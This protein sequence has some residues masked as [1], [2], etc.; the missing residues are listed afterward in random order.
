MNSGVAPIWRPS[1]ASNASPLMVIMVIHRRYLFA[2][3]F[4]RFV[5]EISASIAT[6]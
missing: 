2:W 1:I 3:T 4:G 6:V 5:N